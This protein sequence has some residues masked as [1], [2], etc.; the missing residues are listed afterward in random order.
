MAE[1]QPFGPTEPDRPEAEDVVGTADEVADRVPAGDPADQLTEPLPKAVRS[2]VVA[3][4]ADR[5]AALPP[6]D[7]PPALRAVARF[8]PTRRTRLGAVAL[9]TALESDTAFRQRIAAGVAAMFPDVA[10]ALEE[11]S[12]LPAAGPDDVAAV[13][14]LLRPPGWV[15][16]VE[17]C[18]RV[19]AQEDHGDQRSAAVQ[20]ATRH[21]E[22]L[23]RALESERSAKER[24]RAE[25][26]AAKAES[27]GLR[28][29]LR[30]AVGAARKAE[31]A[32]REA[33]RLAQAGRDA[34]ATQ[35][36]ATQAELRRM[37]GRLA[38]AEAALEA[39]RSNVRA[40]RAADDVRLRVLLDALHD[41][42][43]GIRDELGVAPQTARPADTVAGARAPSAAIDAVLQAGSA[44]GMGDDDPAV[45]DELL[46]LPRVHLV[47][48]GYNVTKTGYGGLTLQEQRARLTAGL[49]ALAAQS[50]AEVTCVFD[51][52][53]VA[54]RVPQSRGVR[55]LF[56]D[57]G[58]T[59]DELIRRLVRAEPVGRAVVVVSTDREVADGVSRAGAR[60]V[61]SAMLLRRLARS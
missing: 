24:L 16:V 27:A 54:V 45:L 26:T 50:R 33:S 11:G 2:R 61:P 56:S 43:T 49:S 25:L 47:V 39:M 46:A 42:A 18:A 40:G 37:R 6:Q 35:A 48:D 13:A 12:P 44:R 8:T 53:D 10:R 7:V 9:S 60:P 30:E 3:L 19:L 58:E 36:A 57:P 31:Q 5:L 21:H 17:G 4:A 38:D 52:A 22:R 28:R 41:A 20:E 51:G 14:Y 1:P 15:G 32:A 34:D 23:E 59:A 29:S 55:V